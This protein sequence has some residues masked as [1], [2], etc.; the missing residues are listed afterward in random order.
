M[1]M[2]IQI[3]LN[4]EAALKL[5]AKA[6]KRKRKLTEYCKAVLEKAAGKKG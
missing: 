3:S 4:D 1:S 6:K 2:T 5:A